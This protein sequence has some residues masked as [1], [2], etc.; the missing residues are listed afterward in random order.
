MFSIFLSDGRCLGR[1]ASDASHTAASSDASSDASASAD[2]VSFVPTVED[3]A[4]MDAA[5][6]AYM[7]DPE[8]EIVSVVSGIK[9]RPD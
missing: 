7:T 4:R 8:F 2:V 5:T 1:R 9:F 6:I 3:R